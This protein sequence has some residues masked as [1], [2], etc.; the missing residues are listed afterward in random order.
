MQKAQNFA[1]ILLLSVILVKLL[2]GYVIVTIYK[3]IH[4]NDQLR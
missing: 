3:T 2:I 1:K 4:L